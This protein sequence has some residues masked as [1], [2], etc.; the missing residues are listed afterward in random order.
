MARGPDLP[1]PTHAS[2]GTFRLWMVAGLVVLVAGFAATTQIDG[3]QAEDTTTADEDKTT[4]TTEDG[5]EG[6]GTSDT[7]DTTDGSTTTT[8]SGSEE[9]EGLAPLPGNDW[10]PAAQEQFI[11]DCVSAD[12]LNLGSLLGLT[13]ATPEE[14]CGCLYDEVSTSGIGL[15]AFNEGWTD[16]TF[17]DRPADDPA[18]QVI[19]AAS[20]TCAMQV[21]F[22]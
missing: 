9:G 8:A 15:D 4:S 2:P 14:I 6:G 16:P 13:T 11:V 7:T 17:E 19:M 10:G 12:S 5:S 20:T 3:L 22:G 18:K 21:G 1:D